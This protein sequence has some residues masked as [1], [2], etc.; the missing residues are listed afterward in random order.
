[1]ANLQRTICENWP[2]N[3]QYVFWGDHVS[4]LWERNFV[5]TFYHLLMLLKYWLFVNIFKEHF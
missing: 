4:Q 2:G 1:M 3:Q 5:I